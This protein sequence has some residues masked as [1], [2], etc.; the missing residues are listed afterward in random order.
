MSAS[1]KEPALPAAL[2][3]K[4]GLLAQASGICGAAAAEKMPSGKRGG[5]SLRYLRAT[6][7]SSVPGTQ[8]FS[9]E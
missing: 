2:A 6:A 9:R 7:F 1:F 4:G 8:K 5:S 3:G